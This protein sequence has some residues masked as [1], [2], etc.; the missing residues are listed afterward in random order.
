MEDQKNNIPNR[1]RDT[2]MAKKVEKIS[3]V[4]LL[5]TISVSPFLAMT[6]DFDS[7]SFNLFW[8]K[9]TGKQMHFRKCAKIVLFLVVPVSFLKYLKV[10]KKRRRR[11]LKKHNCW[12]MSFYSIFSFLLIQ[13]HFQ[14]D[15]M[16]RKGLTLLSKKENLEWQWCVRAKKKASGHDV[17]ILI[18]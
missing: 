15:M 2:V 4:E 13:W 12:C 5:N 9:C 7:L 10:F 18:W 17:N 3:A 11:K 6:V 1:L 8:T 14:F 16:L